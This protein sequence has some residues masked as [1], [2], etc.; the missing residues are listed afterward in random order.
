MPRLVRIALVYVLV[1]VAFAMVMTSQEYRLRLVMGRPS[2]PLMPLLAMHL[3]GALLWAA[4]TP[5]VVA[6]GERLPFRTHRARGIVLLAISVPVLA[7]AHGFLESVVFRWPNFHTDVVII[8]TILAL[9]RL[10]CAGNEAR[11][12]ETHAAELLATLMR[13]RFDELHIRLQTDFLEHTLHTIGHRIRAGDSSSEALIVA[14]S[15]LLRHVLHL[16]RQGRTTLEEELDLLDSYL[17]FHELLSGRRI[18]SRYEF[19]EPLLSAEVPLMMLQPLFDEAITGARSRFLHI[20]VRGRVQDGTLRLE[21]ED[22]AGTTPR[23][24]LG[25]VRERVT[26]YLA[27]ATFTAD[28]RSLLHT[29]RIDLPFA[30]G[31]VTP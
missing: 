23:T 15:D 31:A 16:V 2:V 30:A 28:T 29:T 11:Q 10:A 1:W 3:A 22:D 26:R 8:L 5:V 7:L 13:A 24:S 27:G 21:I 25:K 18:E 12:R 9:T 14:L 20:T 6:V 4:F 19:A 17:Y